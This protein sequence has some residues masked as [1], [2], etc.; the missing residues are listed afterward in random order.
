VNCKVPPIE[1]GRYTLHGNVVT[2]DTEI[3]T[4]ETITLGCNRGYNMQGPTSLYC[5]HGNWTTNNFPSCQPG[6]ISKIN[7][8]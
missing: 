2:P 3:K 6:K 4:F 7:E 8:P 1:S 5:L